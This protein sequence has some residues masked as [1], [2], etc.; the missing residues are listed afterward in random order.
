[1]LVRFRLLLLS[2][3]QLNGISKEVSWQPESKLS[4]RCRGP[5]SGLTGSWAELSRG[6]VSPPAGGSV[7]QL[8][9]LC[10]PGFSLTF[11]SLILCWQRDVMV[12][13]HH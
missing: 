1:M 3:S 9:E 13:W 11:C 12:G 2:T 6:D 8:L 5:P 10:L 4:H 7:V